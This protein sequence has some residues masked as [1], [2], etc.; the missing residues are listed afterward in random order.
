MSDLLVRGGTVID[1]SGRPGTRGDVRVRG[2][3]IVELGP[4]LAA[5]GEPELDAGGAV[6]APGFV[7]VHT[8]FDPSLWWDP[9]ADPVALHGVTTVVHGNCSLSLAPVRPDGRAGLI[10]TFGFIED[11]P[12]IAFETGIPWTWR[13]WSEYRAAFD[14]R[15]ST[16]NVGALVGHST[17]REFV[18]GSAAWER[19]A[20]DDERVALAR[21]LMACLEAGG[22]GVS[23]SFIDTDSSGRK[24]PSRYADDAELR[25]LA[26]ALDATG[27]SIFQFVPSTVPDRKLH[28]IERVHAACHGTGVRGSWVQLAS[29]GSSAGLVDDLLNQAGR[30]QLEGPGIYPQVSPRSFDAQ[31]N[32]D[33]TPMFNSLPM[34]NEWVKQSH[35]EK[36]RRLGDESWRDAMRAEWDRVTY[37]VFPKGRMHK[38]RVSGASHPALTRYIG[39]AFST[40]IDDRGVHEADAFADFLQQNELDCAV[41]IIG[42]ANDDPDQVAALLADERTIFGASD[43]GA[44]LQMLCGA[45][46]TTLLL[47]RHVRER[48]DFPLETAVELLSSRPAAVF[49]LHDRGRIAPGLAAD[50]TV[51]A[52]DELVYETDHLVR[53]VPGGSARL[54]RPSGGYRATIVDGH[55]V[56]LDGA[57]TGERPGRMVDR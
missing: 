47:T 43:A 16:V 27:R 9:S 1:G 19:A 32:L 46:D 12:A 44:H 49:G 39:A 4:T 17:L 22:L 50:L 33:Q 48:A 56:Q 38:L 23:A 24:V 29:G 26:E 2:G 35:A 14:A 31:I 30:M 7:D 3:R 10:D 15:G 8:H 20:T 54:T 45:G 41:T 40:Y 18:M 53:D 6:V 37:S 57:Y 34:W 42:L 13:E 5:D 52:L 21:A 28:D 11:I 36:L 55:L 25:A 51:F